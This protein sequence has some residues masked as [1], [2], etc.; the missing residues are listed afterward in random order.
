MAQVPKICPNADICVEGKTLLKPGKWV[1]R[2][3]ANNGQ[4]IADNVACQ[5]CMSSSGSFGQTCNAYS[6]SWRNKTV[7][8]SKAAWKKC[9]YASR[10][11]GW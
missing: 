7:D 11:Y 9:R 4:A 1:L 6:G 8:E 5:T 2:C 3:R 10:V